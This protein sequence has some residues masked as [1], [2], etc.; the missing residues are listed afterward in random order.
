MRLLAYHLIKLNKSLIWHH[1]GEVNASWWFGN[2]N[3][4]SNQKHVLTLRTLDLS[5]YQWP[6]LIMERLI[7][8]YIINHTD[9]DRHQFAYRSRSSTQYAVICLTT[10]ITSFIDESPSNYARYL[11]P[12]F[13]SAFNTIN[14]EYLIPLL[15]YLDS[16]ATAWKSSFLRNR[17]R[18]TIVY[19]LIG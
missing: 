6:M 8:Q 3:Q 10:T 9:L 7:K 2:R 11:F 5:T 18:R 1:Y 16:D 14:V 15:N 13:L 19:I 4:H 12:D 17:T